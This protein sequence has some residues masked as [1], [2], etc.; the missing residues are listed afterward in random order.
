M[1]MYYEMILIFNK[2]QCNFKAIQDAENNKTKMLKWGREYNPER[3]EIRRCSVEKPFYV[4]HQK[5]EDG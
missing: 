3:A 1:I 2:I 4:H 5:R